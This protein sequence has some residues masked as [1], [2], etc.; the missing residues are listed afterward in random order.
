[1]R[2][3]LPAASRAGSGSHSQS[4]SR[5][6]SGRNAAG[7]GCASVG[8]PRAHQNRH[9]SR[10][11]IPV[12][13]SKLQGTPAHRPEPSGRTLGISNRFTCRQ[14][15]TCGPPTPT[16]TQHTN[17]DPKPCARSPRSTR[18]ACGNGESTNSSGANTGGSM[19]HFVSHMMPSPHPI[20]IQ[21]SHLQELE[22]CATQGAHMPV[23]SQSGPTW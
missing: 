4:T 22:N 11:C 14:K 9:M 19:S 10:K 16:W 13:R 1:M 23:P 8:T 20:D 21:H 2:K 18:R 6:A 3:C 7:G 12:E 17:S 5:R 15:R